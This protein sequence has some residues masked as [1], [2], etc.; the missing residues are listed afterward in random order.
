MISDHKITKC[1]VSFKSSIFFLC[2]LVTEPHI[3]QTYT[4]NNWRNH[5]FVKKF[6]CSEIMKHKICITLEKRL[7]KRGGLF[8]WGSLVVFFLLYLNASDIW[9]DKKGEFWRE[10]LYKMETTQYCSIWQKANTEDSVYTSFPS[11]TN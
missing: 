8:V 11:I 3:P 4:D 7:Y 2:K 9:P 5:T 10:W 1:L 6:F